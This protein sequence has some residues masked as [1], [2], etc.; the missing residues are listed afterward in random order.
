MA[1]DLTQ[2]VSELH[3][4]VTGNAAAETIPGIIEKM[5]DA[6]EA[7]A[8]LST[9]DKQNLIAE[10]KKK[11]AEIRVWY[12]EQMAKMPKIDNII[13]NLRS[14][15]P[16]VGKSNRFYPFA[17][18]NLIERLEAMKTADESAGSTARAAPA[19]NWA[20][21]EVTPRPAEQDTAS[22]ETDTAPS[23]TNAATLKTHTIMVCGRALT[24]HVAT[25]DDV[26]NLSPGLYLTNEVDTI[27]KSNFLFV[28]F[29]TD[30]E[31]VTTEFSLGECVHVPCGAFWGNE[32]RCPF[33]D[34][35]QYAHNTGV[36]FSSFNIS[37]LMPS[38][39]NI[40][41]IVEITDRRNAA[42]GMKGKSQMVRIARLA[43]AHG[44][45]L[46]VIATQLSI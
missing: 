22:S 21:E 12:N 29:S 41:K 33:K 34:N 17:V 28:H 16:V 35:C 38:S 36:S 18:K 43:A 32:G 15:I 7:G 25:P 46:E 19:L 20:D 30:G 24:L 11:I 31:M 14:S 42:G 39:L 23:E 3:N 8:V 13:E 44:A 10:K 1:A 2:L 6:I 37:G 9:A 40:N 5:M 4:A 26:E 45:L 27:E